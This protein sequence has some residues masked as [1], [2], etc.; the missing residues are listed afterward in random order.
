[1]P[2]IERFAVFMVAASLLFSRRSDGHYARKG[3]EAE[4]CPADRAYSSSG[5][6]W[7]GVRALRPRRVS[8]AVVDLLRTSGIGNLSATPSCSEDETS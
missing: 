2:D 7:D 1:M 4:P 8:V 5:R 3:E 6:V